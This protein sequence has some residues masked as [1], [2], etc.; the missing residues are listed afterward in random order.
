MNGYGKPIVIRNLKYFIKDF[1]WRYS[2]HDQY[3]SKS[4]ISL[5]DSEND[6]LSDLVSIKVQR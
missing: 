5:I 6:Y 1:D 4:S 3:I 2:L